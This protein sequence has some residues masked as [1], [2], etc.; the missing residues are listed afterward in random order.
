MRILQT[1]VVHNLRLGHTLLKDVILGK[2]SK[3]SRALSFEIIRLRKGKKT[4]IPI[5]S[6][7]QTVHYIQDITKSIQRMQ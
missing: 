5:Q 3:K 4:N 2:L 6:I 7:I 1:E